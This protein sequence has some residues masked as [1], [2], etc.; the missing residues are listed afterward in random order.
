MPYPPDCFPWGRRF[1][2]QSALSAAGSSDSKV[3]SLMP[4]NPQ[5]DSQIYCEVRVYGSELVLYNICIY[6]LTILLVVL[7]D[8]FSHRK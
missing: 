3:K 2:P 7:V 8:S 5:R 4:S 1:I 6:V